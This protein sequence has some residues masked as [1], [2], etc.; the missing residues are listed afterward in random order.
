MPDVN[1]RPQASFQFQDGYLRSAFRRANIKTL[2]EQRQIVKERNRVTPERLG[3]AAQRFNIQRQQGRTT[4]DRFI[5][6]FG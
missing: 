3:T 6:L 1:F 4:Q 2:Q 5:D